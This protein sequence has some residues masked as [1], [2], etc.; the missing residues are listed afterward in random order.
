MKTVIVTG[1]AGFIGSHLVEALLL[2]GVRV[3]GVDDLS[4]GRRENMTGFSSSSNFVFHLQ[5]VNSEEFWY[6]VQD[7]RPAVIY[8]LAARGSVP[9]SI[10]DPMG[11]HEANTSGFANLLDAATAC[12]IQ[13]HIVFASSSSVYGDDPDVM[14]HEHKIGR[15]LSPYA[16]TKQ[17]NEAYAAAFANSYRLSIVGLRFFNVFGPRQLS[18]SSYAAV[19]PKWA[20]RMQKGEVVMVNGS[21]NN[22]RDFTPVRDVIRA[23]LLAGERTE[24]G[25]LPL[26][27]GCGHLTTL[28]DLFLALKHVTGYKEGYLVSSPRAGDVARSVASTAMAEVMIGFRAKMGPERLREE[29]REVVE[30]LRG[31]S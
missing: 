20:S 28:E 27:V 24:R 6:L 2:S 23:I 19:I 11:F 22:G 9:K 4:T 25:F 13:P 10:I 16:A 21:P 26:N 30:Y 18:D 17:A 15:P 14:K 12:D 7:N 29:L 5:D 8:H 31:Q 1:C 3:I